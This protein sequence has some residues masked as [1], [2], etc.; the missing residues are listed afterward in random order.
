MANGGATVTGLKELA[1]A[2]DRLPQTVTADL[3]LVAASTAYR[4]QAR[5]KQILRSKLKTPAHALVDGIVVLDE[6][7]KKRYVV[8]STRPA[9]QPTNLPLWVERGTRFMAARPYMRPAG[10]AEDERYKRDSLKAAESV[11]DRLGEF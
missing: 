7:E 11:I 4:I 8:D 3:R 9:D 5:A 1:A 10:D 6:P 2:I